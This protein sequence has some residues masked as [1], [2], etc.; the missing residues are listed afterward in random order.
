MSNK[1][2]SFFLR[3]PIALSLLGHGLVRLPK[4][5]A[6]SNGLVNDMQKSYL[7]RPLI[8]GFSYVI[9]FAEVI[10]GLFLLLGLFAW[11]TLYAGLGLM[12]LFIFGCT[13]AEDWMPVSAQLIHAGYLAAIL[14][15][16]H[17]QKTND[18]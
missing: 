17:Y 8:V 3:L 5:Q 13:T 18:T 7:Q 11:Q 9:P 14:F 6:F 12:A 1:Y 16:T 10:I 4:L 2:N 15:L